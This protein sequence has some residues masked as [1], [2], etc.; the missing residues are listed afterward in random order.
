MKHRLRTLLMIVCIVLF[1]VWKDEI[2]Q[3]VETLQSSQIAVCDL[4]DSIQALKNDV[5][6]LQDSV[7]NILAKN[8]DL[9][10]QMKMNDIK[11]EVKIYRDDFRHSVNEYHDKMDEKLNILTSIIGLIGVVFGAIIPYIFNRESAK[12]AKIAKEEAENAK[13]QV[14][15]S[16]EAVKDANRKVYQANQALDQAITSVKQSQIEAETAKNAAGKANDKLTQAQL[17]LDDARKSAN[18]AITKAK[19]IQNFILALQETDDTRALALYNKCIVQ[20]DQFAEAYNNRGFLRHKIGGPN[21]MKDAMD[22]YT[23]AIELF[24]NQGHGIYAEAYN[25]RG[26][27]HFESNDLIEAEDDFNAAI[28]KDYA[29]AYLNRGLLNYQKGNVI[30]ARED[31]DNAI[32][33]K[34]NFAEAYYFRGLLR[35]NNYEKQG[36][37][38]DIINAKAINNDVVES[39]PNRC[40]LT[41]KMEDLDNSFYGVDYSKDMKIII[42][43]PNYKKDSFIIPESVTEIGLQAFAGCSSLTSIKIPNNLIKIGYAAFSGCTSLTSIKIPESVTEIGKYAFTDCTALKAIIVDDKNPKYLSKNGVLY[44]KDMSILITFPGGKKPIAIPKSVIEFGELAFKDCTSLTSIVIPDS[45][46]KIG[47][48]AFG[49][50]TSLTSIEIPS[51][52]TEIGD[53]VFSGCTKLNEIHFNHKTPVDFSVYALFDLDKSKIIIYVPEGSGEAYRKSR[54]YKGFKNIYEYNWDWL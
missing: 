29:E 37:I 36:A 2:F 12:N 54:Y 41:D 28:S 38:I 53:R 47:E 3:K 46:T 9:D 27:L 44:S 11:E 25:N 35:Y 15:A 19:A 48:R 17:A 50:C 7:K 4:Q 32:A 39:Y 14:A 24:N 16:Q 18:N 1:F 33:N 40:F 13:T 51:S 42:S 45:V 23:T 49:G 10:L 52:V 21:A 8:P 30:E 22:D 26:I 43:V 5:A 34:S 31:F 6:S 20:D